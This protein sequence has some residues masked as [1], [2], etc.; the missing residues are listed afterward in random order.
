MATVHAVAE[1]DVRAQRAAEAARGLVALA[2]GHV[3]A[4]LDV[5]G[6][7]VAHARGRERGQERARD[8]GAEARTGTATM[9][10]G[11]PPTAGRTRSHVSPERIAPCRAARPA[12]R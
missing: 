3:V 2:H 9:L 4:V 7:R 12:D 11:E 5:G 8:L 1:L 6:H 10:R